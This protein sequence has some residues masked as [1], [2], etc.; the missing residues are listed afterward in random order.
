M[1]LLI[2][3][4]IDYDNISIFNNKKYKFYKIYYNL[5]YIKLLGITFNIKINNF[6][7]KYNLLYIYITDDITLKILKDIEDYLKLRIPKFILIRYINNEKYIIC[8]N[9]Y[10]KYLINNI[11]INIDI[12]KIKYINGNYVPIINII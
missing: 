9:I 12:K 3:N 4:N 8:K 2:K 10:N 7:L 1:Y 5:E 6:I 11:N